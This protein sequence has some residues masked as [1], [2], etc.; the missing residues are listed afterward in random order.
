MKI[1]AQQYW[2]ACFLFA[3]QFAHAFNFSGLNI[4]SHAVECTRNEL[5]ASGVQFSNDT[6]WKE[7]EYTS[8]NLSEFFKNLPPSVLED[9][10]VRD[11]HIIGI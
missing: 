2:I 11:S 1:F 10:K 5:T 6:D 8:R 4:P 3:S 9:I 7:H